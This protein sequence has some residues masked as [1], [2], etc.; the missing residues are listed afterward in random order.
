METKVQSGRLMRWLSNRLGSKIHDL[1]NGRLLGHAFF[2]P[3][4][5]RLFI[6]GYTGTTPLRPVVLPTQRLDYWRQGIGFTGPHEP[7]FSRRS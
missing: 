4:K 6:I 2:L 7:D 1:E 5:G 3:W